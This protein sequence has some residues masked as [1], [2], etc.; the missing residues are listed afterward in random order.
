M[1]EVTNTKKLANKMPFDEFFHFEFITQLRREWIS[2]TIGK[3]IPPETLAQITFPT[4]F[5]STEKFN[6]CAQH[7]KLHTKQSHF[8]FLRRRLMWLNLYGSRVRNVFKICAR[9]PCS[10]GTSGPPSRWSTYLTHTSRKAHNS[11]QLFKLVKMNCGDMRCRWRLQK[12]Q[13]GDERLRW[14][15][16]VWRCGIG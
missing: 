7:I 9:L 4:E 3:I 15:V 8:Q 6:I 12:R 10:L 2:D 16:R 1:T 14:N 5:T 13:V 11:S